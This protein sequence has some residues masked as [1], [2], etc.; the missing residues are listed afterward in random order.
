MRKVLF[1]IAGMLLIAGIAKADVKQGN[2]QVTLSVPQVISLT[3]HTPDVVVVPGPEDY[4][5]NLDAAE[6]EQ[7]QAGT[8]AQ[9]WTPVNPNVHLYLFKCLGGTCCNED[10]VG[11]GFADRAEAIKLTIFTNA[12]NGAN[13]YVHG[14]Q[15][16][17]PQGILRLED[18]F[19]T[20][21]KEKTWVLING[22]EGA[23]ARGPGNTEY[24][25]NPT[26]GCAFYLQ[27]YNEAQ[28]I[29]GVGMATKAPRLVVLKLGI[30]NLDRY[31]EGQYNNTLV[32]TLMPTV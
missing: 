18:T 17:G 29:F 10:F 32:F 14:Q 22:Q 19:L 3:I 9:T 11:K 15:P 30:G 8:S 25:T 12:Q 1:V 23:N 13:L 26:T 2:V 21:M 4:N 20:V 16:E 28:K 6:N 24:C 7:P 5:R 27:M 31:T